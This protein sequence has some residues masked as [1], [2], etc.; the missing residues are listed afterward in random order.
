MDEIDE[1]K[2]AYPIA[3]WPAYCITT[4]RVTKD[5]QADLKPLNEKPNPEVA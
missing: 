4:I 2:C 5:G 1:K 3:R